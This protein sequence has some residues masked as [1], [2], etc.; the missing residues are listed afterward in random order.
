MTDNTY[1]LGRDDEA[2]FVTLAA[3]FERASHNTKT[4]GVVQ[5]YQLWMGSDP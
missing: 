1:E 2:G 3:G 4:G 5:L